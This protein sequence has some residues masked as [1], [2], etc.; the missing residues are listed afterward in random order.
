[1]NSAKDK[2]AFCALLVDADAAFREAVSDMLY[3]Y[4]PS[5]VVEEA[6]DGAEALS[7]VEYLRPN[8]I[9]MEMQL[10]GESGLALTKEIKQVYANILIVILAANN[11]AEHRQ[12]AFW[13]GAESC[14]SK[15]DQLCMQEILTRIEEAIAGRPHQ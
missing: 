2:S 14:I 11:A 3:V 12:Q 8:I 10:P 15:K 6:G 5:I 1:M 4:F 9:F 7:K 13:G